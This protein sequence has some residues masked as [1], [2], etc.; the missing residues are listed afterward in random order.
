[1]P[2]LKYTSFSN[3]SPSDMI[4]WN[5]GSYYFISKYH[6]LSP[7]KKRVLRTSNQKWI[8]V[9]PI[10]SQ[11]QFSFQGGSVKH[12]EATS[13]DCESVARQQA[14]CKDLDQFKGGAVLLYPLHTK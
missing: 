13:L 4:R 1:M 11:S 3:E 8:D 12:L 6:S 7:K 9:F 5:Y 2:D 10:V 14:I